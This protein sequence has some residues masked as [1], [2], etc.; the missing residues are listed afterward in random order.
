MNNHNYKKIID[1]IFS[2]IISE[3]GDGDAVWLYK[4]INQ[5]EI[6]K[7]LTEFNSEHNIPWQISI[8]DNHIFWGSGEEGAII[9]NNENFF[10]SQPSWIILKIKY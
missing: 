8:N 6:I 7:L 5:D 2:S 4:H 3:G 9:T 10:N 1:L